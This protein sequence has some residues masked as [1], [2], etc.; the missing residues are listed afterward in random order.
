MDHRYSTG[1]I[2]LFLIIILMAAI[3]AEF[4]TFRGWTFEDK[5]KVSFNPWYF[6]KFNE[7][8]YLE[9]NGFNLT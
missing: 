7:A 4:E 3:N 8:H 2:I 5:E 1:G 6:E 9:W